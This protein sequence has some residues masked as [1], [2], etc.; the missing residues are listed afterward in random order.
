MQRP[1]KYTR[2]SAEI[3]V[4][5]GE[6][7]VVRAVDVD[8]VPVTG[9]SVLFEVASGNGHL[10]AGLRR[11]VVITDAAGEA[12]VSW[13][14]GSRAGGA[15]DRVAVSS[16]GIRGQRIFRAHTRPGPPAHLFL[17][18]GDRQTGV[19]GRRLPEPLAAVVTDA[20]FNRLRDVM[21]RFRV[22]RGDGALAPSGQ[23]VES[24]VLET[25]SDASGRAVAEW[26]LQS[27]EG[28]AANVVEVDLPMTPEA[29]VVTFTASGKTAGLPADTAVEGLVLDNADRPLPDVTV[30]IPGTAL[31]TRTDVGGYFRLDGV[32]AAPFHLHVD[33]DTTSRDGSWPHLEFEMAPIPGRDN[34][35]G[36]P[37]YL[38]ELDADRFLEVDEATGG[39]LELEELPGFSLEVAPG[40]VT[41]PGGGRSGRISVTQVHFDKVPMVPNFGQ[42]PRLVV[43]IQP[44]GAIF[45]PPA[46]LSLPNV[47]GLGAGETTEMYSFDHDLGR[48]VGIG[49][50]VVSEDRSR[51]VSAPG[52][53]VIKAG[54]H[55]GGNPATT[56]TPH[57]CG[58]CQRCDGSQCAADSCGVAAAK[59]C[60]CPE[61]GQESACNFN[62]RCEN[63]VCVSDQVK[64]E[65]IET[66][67]L[68]IVNQPETFTI[69]SN[70][71]EKVRWFA[72]QGSPNRGLGNPIVTTWSQPGEYRV[73]AFCSDSASETVEVIES[74]GAVDTEIV[75]TEVIMPP[76]DGALGE[77][78][79]MDLLGEYEGCAV[80]DK[81][82][83]R[84]VKL[85]S[86]HGIGVDESQYTNVQSPEDQ[87]I[88]KDN[89]D[90]V[91]E[92][93]LPK[94]WR[95]TPGSSVRDYP[96]GADAPPSTALDDD[97]NVV[98]YDATHLVWSHERFHVDDW[99]AN[100]LEAIPAAFA[101]EIQANTFLYC[102]NCS[103]RESGRAAFDRL[104]R[105]VQVDIEQ[106]WLQEHEKRAFEAINP[107]YRQFVDGIR[108]RGSRP[109]NADWP[110]ECKTLE[111]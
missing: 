60:A 53:G 110:F 50:G 56:G 6:A 4:L 1:T 89:C 37:I 85:F 49:P 23:A 69:I 91:V 15:T 36:M 92:A 80:N 2:Q 55:C 76:T 71:P 87:V 25:L 81:W 83:P 35:L 78:Q 46:R 17:D 32:P 109:E 73:S 9:R 27:S 94:D 10:G 100:V 84:L 59:S 65:E 3:G 24:P 70:K 58:T 96:Q 39:V 107:A 106:V 74:C 68:A 26:R 30:W 52:F 75:E 29:G 77:V 14:L 7:L 108:E 51:V 8:G 31:T 104:L 18:A 88:N 33:G 93:M 19:A 38:V 82:C 79:H 42:Q 61:N 54:W 86:T 41:F 11:R 101:R 66:N 16:P 22:V 95:L 12:R 63:G 45:D 64:V 62:Y 43:T 28:I 103:L 13:T 5:L 44:A 34:D 67:C 48:F 111:P 40:S 105:D 57:D 20:G 98:A 102:G 90:E 97:G 47:D 72:E 21:L 99:R